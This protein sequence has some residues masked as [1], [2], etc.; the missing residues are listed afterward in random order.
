MSRERGIFTVQTKSGPRYRVKWRRSDGTQASE[1][2][3]TMKEAKERKRQIDSSKARGYL[4][5]DRRAKMPFKDF[6]AEFYE[7]SAQARSTKRRRDGILKNHLNPI[8]GERLIGQIRP[9][10]VQKVVNKWISDGL[11]PHSIRNH[12]D[13]ARA[14]F[15]AAM[16]EDL[17]QKNPVIGVTK[18]K[19]KETRRSPLTPDQCHAFL[20]AIEPN[21]RPHINFGL[22]TGVRWEEFANLKIADFQP[23]KGYVM[24]SKSKT[25]KGIR[26]IPLDKDEIDLISRHIAD[27][28][29]TGADADSPLF[30]S[31][32]GHPLIYSN[33][34]RRVWLPARAKA[35]LND[36]TFHDL[37]R[38]HATMLVAEG[39]D[40]KVVQERM[41]HSSISTTLK[42][43]AV[44]TEQRKMQA[45]GVKNRYLGSGGFTVLGQAL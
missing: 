35:G 7:T 44:A 3:R 9:M 1:T 6:A 39:H 38:T 13:V 31:P 26:K 20:A 40:P 29:R 28:G 5:D 33:F 22:A 45:A 18:P 36:I 27:T 41:G 24:V 12:L 37:R 32:Q 23:L 17:I 34:R 14:I 30:T 10:D 21:Y 42:Y 25:A 15:A 16:L 4:L 2:F 19:T 8:L 11:S 43:Y